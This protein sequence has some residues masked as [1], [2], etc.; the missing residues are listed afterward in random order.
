MSEFG[1]R[2]TYSVGVEEIDRQHKDFLK[3]INRL[4]ILH[5]KGDP[6]DLIW[7]F[8]QEL[9]AYAAYHFISEENIMVLLK[10]PGLSRQEVEHQKLL[11]VFNQKAKDYRAGSEGVDSLLHFLMDWFIAHT[12]L[13]DQKIGDHLRQRKL[14]SKL[15]T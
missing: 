3:L 11:E 1:W 6:P 14:N 13:E 9:G 12:T 8:L 7:R 4:N 2:V 15:G 10:Y 5:G